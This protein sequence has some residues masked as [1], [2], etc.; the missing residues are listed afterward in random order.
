MTKIQELIENADNAYYAAEYDKAVLFYMR[1][2]DL[3][4]NNAH[5]QQQ[6]RKAEANQN[7]MVNA[8][9]A[10]Y[11]TEYD[12][13]IQL[14][15]QVLDLD[16]DNK[17]A[18]EQI[19]KAERSQPSKNIKLED[20]PSE[21][22]QLYMRSRSFIA[23]GDLLGAKKLLKKAIDVARRVDVDFSDARGL[24]GN[25]QNALAAEEFK[26]NAFEQLDTQQWAKAADNLNS[27]INL[28][29]TD[30]VIRSL[31]LHLN[32]L[33]D[34]GNLINSLNVE[35]ADAKEH[36]RIVKEIRDII[37]LTNKTTVLSKLWQEVVR[38][39]GEYNNKK[40]QN[41]EL[42]RNIVWGNLIKVLVFSVIIIIAI[43]SSVY[44]LPH[45]RPVIDCSI[46]N[47][48]E[49]TINYPNYI[50][51]GDTEEI[52]LTIRNVGSSEINGSVLIAFKDAK[53]HFMDDPKIKFEDLDPSEQST[54]KEIRF[55]LNELPM[56]NARQFINFSAVIIGNGAQC[57]SKDYFILVSPI[58]GL[59]KLI[60]FLLSIVVVTLT[61]LFKDRIK[62][63]FEK[64]LSF[65]KVKSA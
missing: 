1:A 8:D 49:V 16:P 62:E 17:H 34:A 55:S 27:A 30:D 59:R 47:G 61:G 24:L 22:L 28:D 45:A 52:K 12:K 41:D 6:L 2:L 31:V 13:A 5:A 44:L 35:I 10:Y 50:A 42:R 53:V 58:Y 18:Q 23:A 9:T 56:L 51:N 48:L 3:D 26:K 33:I 46:E 20:L 7:L 29:P 19:R 15:M 36:S 60:G 54:T 39:F 25:I 63:W 57:T 38:L 4:P 65:L 21:A 43:L 64:L 11:S 14:Y 32:S 37:K 40:K